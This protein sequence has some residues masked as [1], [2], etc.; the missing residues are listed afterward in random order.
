MK[1]H[2]AW[3]RVTAAAATT[4]A[5]AV[6]GDAFLPVLTRLSQQATEELALAHTADLIEEDTARAVAGQRSVA[7]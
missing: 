6:S 1:M 7:A 4:A 3:I 2:L 5:T